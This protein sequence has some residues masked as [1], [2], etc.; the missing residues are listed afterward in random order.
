MACL[1]HSKNVCLKQDRSHLRRRLPTQRPGC[2]WICSPPPL[3]FCVA[4]VRF[5]ELPADTL[6]PALFR[7]PLSPTQCPAPR[8]YGKQRQPSYWP[9]RSPR[10]LPLKGPSLTSQPE[11][12]TS[13]PVRSHVNSWLRS[14]CPPS[15]KIAHHLDTCLES[16]PFTCQ[17]KGRPENKGWLSP[18]L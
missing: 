4:I 8:L 3:S 16:S 7:L 15:Q 10:V 12:S 18:R 13:L 14:L 11:P 1:C 2:R 5:S 6:L 17:V 9:R